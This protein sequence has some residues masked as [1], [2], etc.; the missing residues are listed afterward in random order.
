DPVRLIFPL[1]IRGTIV[2]PRAN[3]RT[4]LLVGQHVDAFS[5]Q[6]FHPCSDRREIVSR[7][8]SVHVCSVP[9]AAQFLHAGSDH[10]KI[11]CGAG[12]SHV[13]LR[14]SRRF[15]ATITDAPFTAAAR[16]PKRG[17]ANCC[18]ADTLRRPF[19]PIGF[20][21]GCTYVPSGIFNDEEPPPLHGR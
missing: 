14:V 4:T 9:L 1:L 8:G 13:S 6:F 17:A 3:W 16:L 10:R 5:A 18:Q 11:I 21:L 19:S 15:A 12:L 20:H 2:G 7:A